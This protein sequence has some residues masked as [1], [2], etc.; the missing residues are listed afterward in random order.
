MICSVVMVCIFLWLIFVLLLSKYFI[1]FKFCN[2]MVFIK[3][4]FILF[5]FLFIDVL[6][7]IRRL[8][9]LNM[10]VFFLNLKWFYFL[11]NVSI[12]DFC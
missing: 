12:L 8:I 5:V 10:V 11:L 3:Y 1:I 2:C 7:F 6:F 4:E 9:V